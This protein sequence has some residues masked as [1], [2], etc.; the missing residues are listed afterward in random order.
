MSQTRSFE[1]VPTSVTLA[2][3]FARE[4]LSGV[5]TKFIQTAELIV[6]ELAS[7]C[8]VHTGSPFDLQIVRTADEIRIAVTDHEGGDPVLRSP[9]P[10]DIRGRGL[11]IVD[12]LSSSWGVDRLREG[13]KTV[14]A[15]IAV[16]SQSGV[17]S[18]ITA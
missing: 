18:T 16:S 2:R 3:Q 6:S 8:V 1:H 13:G 14:W 17:R 4:A 9:G 15:L 5:P 11:Q 12:M 10:T 7:N